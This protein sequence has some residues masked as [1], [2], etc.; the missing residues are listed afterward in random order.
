MVGLYKQSLEIIWETSRRGYH[1]E[2]GERDILQ[3]L[4]R[5]CGANGRELHFFPPLRH[6]TLLSYWS[7]KEPEPGDQVSAP[8]CGTSPLPPETARPPT[9]L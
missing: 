7:R 6:L 5:S 1:R 3:F 4:F 8:N 9:A 2:I